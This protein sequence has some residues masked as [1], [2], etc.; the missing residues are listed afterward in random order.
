MLSDV[1]LVSRSD[2][3]H[4]IPV[5]RNMVIKICVGYAVSL[6]AHKNVKHFYFHDPLHH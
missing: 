6:S 1:T 3:I 2:G 4:V 5:C